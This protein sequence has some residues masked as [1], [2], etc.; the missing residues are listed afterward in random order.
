MKRRFLV[1]EQPGDIVAEV[2][3]ATG[4]QQIEQL[5]APEVIARDADVDQE[6]Q[7]HR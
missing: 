5:I 3:L 7:L 4:P 1:E 2:V 6:I